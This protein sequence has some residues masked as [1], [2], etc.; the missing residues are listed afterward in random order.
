MTRIALAAPVRPTGGS[1]N[2]V[3]AA[4]WAALLRA[5]GHDVE[6]VPVD[7]GDPEPDVDGLATAEV[8]IALHAR[9]VAALVAAWRERFGSRPLVVALTGTDL[10]LDLSADGTARSSAARSSV[11]TADRLI[12]LQAAAVARLASFDPAWGAKAVVVHQSVDPDRLP[13]R[14]PVV[15]EFRVVVLA[16]LRAVK[17]PLLAAT[18]VRRLPNDRPIV[19]HH[20]GGAV[21]DDWEARA[22]AEAAD[23]PRYVW[24]RELERTAAL[25]L[26]ASA[27]VLAC[28]S[29]QEG[30]ANV[31]TEALALGVPVVGTRIE[32]NTGLLGDDHPGLVPVGDAGA[33][34]ALFDRLLT[35][36]AALADL[37]NRSLARRT[38]TDPAIE[39][40][41]LAALVAAV[42]PASF[43]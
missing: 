5:A 28:T 7:E 42:T 1:G 30:G 3:T 11:A 12:V 26:L 23:N 18:A 39:R 41:T 31:V 14:S 6:I 2:D 20:A 25:D 22:T 15:G 34:A 4:R 9:R 27:D 16:H 32:G 10:Y 13:A 37:A 35:D 36:P 21:D 24:H 8:L 38:L 17:D 43:R 29:Q 33:L 40:R 19:V